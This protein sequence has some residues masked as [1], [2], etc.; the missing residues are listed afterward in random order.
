M[1][2]QRDA[3]GRLRDFRWDLGRSDLPGALAQV[4]AF[5]IE[6]AARF[7]AHFAGGKRARAAA[8]VDD[9]HRQLGA[10]HERLGQVLLAGGRDRRRGALSVCHAAY[11]VQADARSSRHGLRHDVLVTREEAEQRASY[12]RLVAAREVHGLGDRHAG[13][14]GELLGPLLVECL[15]R[16]GRT[17]AGKRDPALLEQLLRG[18]V[19][20]ARPVQGEDE[21]ERLRA[22]IVERFLQRPVRGGA[23]RNEFLLE[24]TRMRE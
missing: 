14:R 20:A 24:R 12:R 1:H 9:S 22:W 21:R 5:V 6:R 19:L 7:D 17:R 13:R 3:L 16:R 10:A 8:I 18:P 2:G 15:R 11:E 4:L 23:G